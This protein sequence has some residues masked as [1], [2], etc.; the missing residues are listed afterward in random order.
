MEPEPE[1]VDSSIEEGARRLAELVARHK[2]D[3]AAQSVANLVASPQPQMARRDAV[4]RKVRL[5]RLLNLILAMTKRGSMRL[6]LWHWRS[7]EVSTIT[8][9]KHLPHKACSEARSATTCVLTVVLLALSPLRALPGSHRDI[10][11]ANRWAT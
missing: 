11:N 9:V 4:I 10:L 8:Y 3:Q 6:M 1:T 2:A 7:V 5:R